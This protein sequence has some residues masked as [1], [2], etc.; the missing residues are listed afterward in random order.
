[1][2]RQSVQF[3]SS[4]SREEDKLK[5][6]IPAVVEKKIICTIQFEQKQR[7]RQTEEFHTSSGGEED[8]L[9]NSV[10][11]EAEKKIN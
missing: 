6:S 1:M 11:A 10:P 7:R 5:N 9:H 4:R 2:R 3:S 8:N